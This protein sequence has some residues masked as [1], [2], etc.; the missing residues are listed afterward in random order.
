MRPCINFRVCNAVDVY[1]NTIL[2]GYARFNFAAPKLSPRCTSSSR[3]GSPSWP[4][5]QARLC[6]LRCSLR[7]R[8]LEC[9][10]RLGTRVNVRLLVVFSRPLLT[11]VLFNSHSKRAY[12][13]GHAMLC[14]AA[15]GLAI[16]LVMC[17]PEF[18]PLRA[19]TSTRS[20]IVD[21]VGGLAGEPPSTHVMGGQCLN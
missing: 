10:T 8:G 12:E 7:T 16:E 6:W 13:T 14:I 2:Y 15:A 19:F 3:W 21:Q 4:S 17:L 9:G 1:L 20:V 18:E 11:A 5:T